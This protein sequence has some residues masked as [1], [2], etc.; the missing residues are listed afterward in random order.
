VYTDNIPLLEHAGPGRGK[1][2]RGQQEFPVHVHVHGPAA[3]RHR[4][5]TPAACPYRIGRSVLLWPAGT[6]TDL[7]SIANSYIYN[8]HN[9]AVLNIQLFSFFTF[10]LLIITW[11]LNKCHT[12]G[13]TSKFIESITIFIIFII[14]HVIY[15]LYR[16]LW[17]QRAIIFTVSWQ[18]C[19]RVRY[20]TLRRTDKYGN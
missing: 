8:F 14:H 5:L 9:F 4:H 19:P 3:H 2:R 11:T 7:C 6:K 18:Y 20:V 1:A 16:L 10:A 13:H 17:R 15:L 12:I